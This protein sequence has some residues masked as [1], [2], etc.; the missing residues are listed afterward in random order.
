MIGHVHEGIRADN[1]IERPG[2]LDPE[3][4]A[5]D[6]RQLGVPKSAVG[7]SVGRKIGA[8][9]PPEW[10]KLV[11]QPPSPTSNVED[12]H[13]SA[14]FARNRNSNIPLPPLELIVVLTKSPD[15]IPLVPLALV[16]RHRR[17]RSVVPQI[18]VRLHLE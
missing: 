2:E 9:Y 10:Q 17:S 7:D 13:A 18:Q 1:Q 3:E 5:A 12:A 4:V 6:Q 16:C 15:Q 14:D 8:P 11:T